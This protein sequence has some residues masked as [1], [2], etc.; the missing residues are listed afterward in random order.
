MQF[1]AVPQEEL[2]P[3]KTEILPIIINVLKYLAPFIA[4]IILALFVIRPLL[5]SLTINPVPQ[6]ALPGVSIPLPQTVSEIEKRM[7]L[8]QKTAGENVIEWAKKNP[9]EASNLIKNWIKES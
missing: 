4:L 1:E 2:P 6:K 8:G 5:K 3:A 9:K 7:E